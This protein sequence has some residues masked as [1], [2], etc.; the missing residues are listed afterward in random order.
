MFW[1]Q[2]T[3]DFAKTKIV[4]KMK[5]RAEERLEKRTRNEL[6]REQAINLWRK[7]G[8]WRISGTKKRI[9]CRNFAFA[10]RGKPKKAMKRKEGSGRPSSWTPEDAKKVK[11]LLSKNPCLTA[12]QIKQKVPELQNCRIRTIQKICK[13]NMKLP[14]CKMAKKPSINDQMKEQRLEFAC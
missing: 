2:I 1:V 6:K 12:R 10:K 8:L 5:I 7:N 3:A 14:S 11:N 13:D 4:N 9:L